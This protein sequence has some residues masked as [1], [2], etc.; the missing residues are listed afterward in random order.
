VAVVGEFSGL[1]V[2][3]IEAIKCSDPN[4][5]FAVFKDSGNSAFCDTR[6]I[7]VL[8]QKMFV[9]TGSGIILIETAA[10]YPNDTVLIGEDCFQHRDA[11]GIWIVGAMP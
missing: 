1:F 9:D 10:A 6:T 5:F 4:V 11:E 3:A 2:Q 7:V 8:M